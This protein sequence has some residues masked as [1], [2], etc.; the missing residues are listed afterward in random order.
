MPEPIAREQ[1]PPLRRIP[2]AEREHA[3]QPRDDIDSPGVVSAQEHFGVGLRRKL[4]PPRSSS[5]SGRAK[6]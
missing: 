6:L 4:A 1:E 2:Q 5:V 3:A